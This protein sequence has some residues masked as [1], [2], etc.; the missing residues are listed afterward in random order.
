MSFIISWY[1]KIYNPTYVGLILTKFQE[2]GLLKL[3]WLSKIDL[4]RTENLAYF[5]PFSKFDISPGEGVSAICQQILA[6]LRTRSLETRLGVSACRR[7]EQNAKPDNLAVP[8]AVIAGNT[9]KCYYR[10]IV[11][12]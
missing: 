5:W 4:A 8:L 11:S 7:A 1:L 12:F 6:T 10:Y 3:A 9:S 2:F